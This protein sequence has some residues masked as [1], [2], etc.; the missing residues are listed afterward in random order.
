MARTR[1]KICGVTRERDAVRAADLGADFVGLNFW[2]GSPRCVSVESARRIAREVE[3][4]LEIVGVFV[5]QQEAEI[6]EIARRAGLDLLQFHGHEGPDAVALFGDRAI[7]VLRAGPDFDAS[8]VDEFPDVWGFLFDCEHPTLLGGS[9]VSWPY[10]AV[11]GL[12]LDKPVIVAGGL[13]PGN[14]VEA[15]ARSGAD[16]VDVSS[17]VESQPG[18]KD[19]EL[20]KQFI[21]EVHDAEKE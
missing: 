16:I 12:N 13:R 8:I 7:K 10:E 9:G 19:P 4:Q 18:V 5:D 3:G 15:I 2:P 1:I 21:H 20:L 14:V 11:A 17:G 6:R